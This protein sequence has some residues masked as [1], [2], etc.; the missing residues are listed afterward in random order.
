[1]ALFGVCS[2]MVVKVLNVK[3]LG[4]KRKFFEQKCK[5]VVNNLS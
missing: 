4:N 5:P 2:K 1:M 3:G